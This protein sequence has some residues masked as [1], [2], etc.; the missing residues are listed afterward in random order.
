[1]A[2]GAGLCL[3]GC[4]ATPRN[5]RPV[6]VGLYKD[7]GTNG[8]GVTNCMRI[9]E[10]RPNTTCKLL[11]AADIKAGAL[12][13]LDV[14]IMPGGYSPNQEKALGAA[15]MDAIRR[16]VR[17]GGS[18][19]GICAGYGLAMGGRHFNGR[20]KPR[21]GLVPF[22]SIP[23]DK[24]A[25]LGKGL[26]D[27]DFNGAQRTVLYSL[28]P[29]SAPSANA[30]PEASDVRVLARYAG[31]VRQKL[32]KRAPLTGLPAAIASRYGKGR[33]FITSFHPEARANTHDIV[34]LGFRHLVPG[35]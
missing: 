34:E 5:E 26:V 30:V 32:K 8:G 23:K 27:I 9:V 15:G 2:I 10:R 28:G 31:E 12:D 25:Q 3:L 17:E 20:G 29:R 6:R 4:I 18:Y 21:L 22:E 13:D 24:G 16:F 1:M 35:R 14:L 19:F 33:V 7:L 11:M